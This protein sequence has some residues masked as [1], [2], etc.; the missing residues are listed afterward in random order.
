MTPGP[1]RIAVSLQTPNGYW[2][3]ENAGMDLAMPGMLWKMSGLWWR[4][5]SR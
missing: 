2:R 5:R 1:S 3:L 4:S